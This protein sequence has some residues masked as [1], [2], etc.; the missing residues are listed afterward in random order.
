MLGWHPPPHW[1]RGG[2]GA[3]APRGG[4][5]AHLHGEVVAGAAVVVLVQHF[6]GV[7]GVKL[8]AGQAGWLALGT[9]RGLS[10]HRD[11]PPLSPPG[12]GTWWSDRRGS[13]RHC[14]VAPARSWRLLWHSTA[15]EGGAGGVQRARVPC[16][17]PCHRRDRDMWPWLTPFSRARQLCRCGARFPQFVC[18]RLSCSWTNVP[19]GSSWGGGTQGTP[20]QATQPPGPGPGAPGDAAMAGDQQLLTWLMSS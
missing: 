5:R 19:E 12:L 10:P 8:V 4:V 14:R 7:T 6:G 2:G 18:T 3:P 16:G 13:A 17:T 9:E 1:A 11:T 15:D 20:C